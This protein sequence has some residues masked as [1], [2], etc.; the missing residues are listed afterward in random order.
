MKNE[1]TINPYFLLFTATKGLTNSLKPIF[2]KLFIFTKV[3]RDSPFLKRV[4]TCL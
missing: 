1:E 3:V 4:A 2:I